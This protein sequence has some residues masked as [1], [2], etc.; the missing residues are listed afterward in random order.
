MTN[1]S[2]TIATAVAA[3]LSFGLSHSSFA[4]PA[5]D[6][7]ATVAE[8]KGQTVYF[9]AWGGSPAINDYIQWAADEVKSQYDITVEHV[10]IDDAALVVQR[11]RN[12]KAAGTDAGKVDLIWV[13]G[14]NF[15]TLKTEGLLSAPFTAELPNFTLVDVDNKPTTVVDFGVPTDGLESP[16]GMAQLV[17]YY[18][19]AY[20]EK[21]PANLREFATIA[22][23]EPG[24]YSY[25]APPAFHGTTFIK[26]ALYELVDDPAVLSQSV[27]DV[28]FAAV[29]APLWDYLDA[30]HPN[31]WQSGNNFPKDGQHMKQL[32]NDGE[33]TIGMTFNP[34]EASRAIANGEL[35]DSVRSY[36]HESGTIGNTHFFAIPY[37]SQAQAAAKVVANFLLSPEAQAHKANADIWGDPTVLAVSKLTAEQQALFAELPAG[38]ASLTAEELGAVL[39]EPHTSWVSA[40]EAEWLKRYRQ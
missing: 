11:I 27:D 21:P 40:L 2:T 32:V 29:T 6:F 30:L 10:K 34:N 37:N 14:E 36:V 5:A 18:D 7:P 33:L 31:L 13:N 25:P 3:A 24:R 4:D 19:S 28:D 1:R 9:N 12:E 8:A 35:P 16:W 22:A 39:P 38:A 26:Q 23:N 20:L 15:K 17:F